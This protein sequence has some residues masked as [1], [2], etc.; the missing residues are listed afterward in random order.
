MVGTLLESTVQ[1][2]RENAISAANH[3]LARQSLEAHLRSDLLH[4][5]SLSLGPALISSAGAC[6]QIGLMKE[7]GV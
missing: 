5:G 4:Q 6:V 3:N 1:L 2:V 7:F